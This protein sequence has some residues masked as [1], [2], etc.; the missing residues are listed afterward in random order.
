MHARRFLLGPLLAALI[1]LVLE[2]FRRF[3]FIIP[4]PPAILLLVVVFSSFFSGLSSGLFSGL[5]TW[6]YLIMFYS[7]QAQLFA[8]TEENFRR[9]AIWALTI[10]LIAIMVGVLKK[11]AEKAI[12]SQLEERRKAEESKAACDVAEAANEAKTTFLA[13]MSHEIRTPLGVVVGFSELLASEGVSPA[14]K[15]KYVGTI[16]RASE[17]LSGIIDDILDLSKVEAGKLEISKRLVSIDEILSDLNTVWRF[18]AQAKGLKFTISTPDS[19]SIQ[20]S[21]DPS[22]LRQIFSNVIGNAIKFTEKG[23]IEIKL[24]TV[25]QEGRLHLII[26]VSDTGLGISQEQRTKLFRPFSQLDETRKRKF[27]G[28]GLGLVLSRQLA[29]LLGGDVAL[30]ESAPGRGSTFRISV[31]AGTVGATPKTP[32]E[33]VRTVLQSRLDGMNILV[34][35]DSLDNQTLFAQLLELAGASVTTATDGKEAVEKATAEVFDVILMDLQMPV[36]DGYEATSLLRK[37]GYQGAIFALTAHALHEERERCIANGF[38]RHMSKPINREIMID[39]I[40]HFRR[41]MVS[42]A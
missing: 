40:A 16:Q 9:I 1:C 34:V 30:E 31:D 7:T 23:S 11:R 5:I 20:I 8:Y 32:A 37:Q 36:M 6:L 25:S 17:L 18:K 13:N 12:V 2:I 14:E 39:Q 26:E 4:N 29:R 22:R 21:T 42:D 27:G 28:T 19:L 3:I 35:D 38:D 10:P 41:R 24:W 15:K 33:S